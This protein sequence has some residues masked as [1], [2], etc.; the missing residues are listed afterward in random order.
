M[1]EPSFLKK[2]RKKI[3]VPDG[4]ETGACRQGTLRPLTPAPPSGVAAAEKS[5]AE[6]NARKDETI[7]SAGLCQPLVWT[8]GWQGTPGRKKIK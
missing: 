7:I 1:A 5:T 2:K 4:F 3:S 8:C 6:R